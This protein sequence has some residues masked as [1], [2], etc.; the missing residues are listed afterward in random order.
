MRAILRLR[1]DPLAMISLAVIL[2]YVVLALLVALGWAGTGW[3]ERVG[4]KFLDPAPGH[5]LGTDRQGRDVLSRVLYG[6]KIALSV[7]GLTAVISVVIGTVLGIVAG[8]YHG[9]VDTFIVG[10]YST[11][12]SIPSILLLIAL[13]YVAGRGLSGVLLAFAATYW[14][15]PCRVI[16]G[17]VLKIK[18]AEYIDA[19]RTLGFSTWRILTRHIFPNTIHL[20]LVNFA[21]VFVAAIKAE[22]I[23]SYLG[24]GIQGEPSWGTMIQ[25]SRGELINGFFWQIGAASVA[26]FILVL[27]FNVFGDALQDAL[28]PKGSR[29]S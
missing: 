6:A 22:V 18:N 3:E 9:K 25:Q 29:F 21:L 24:L 12:Q 8:W 11:V 17:E 27:A 2:V 15:V 19:A 20:V 5:W 13:A 28:D 16:R 14:V 7:G 26:M 4:A 23:L 1:R 10:L